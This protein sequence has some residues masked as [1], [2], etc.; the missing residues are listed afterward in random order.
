MKAPTKTF[1]I[2]ASYTYL[3]P[4]YDAYGFPEESPLINHDKAIKIL[5]QEMGEL[6]AE[7]T[8]TDAEAVKPK[9]QRLIS[10]NQHLVAIELH[11]G[12]E[13]IVEL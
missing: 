7:V 9:L 12:D 11:P 3:Q 4:S 1:R 6:V 8:A 5:L 10:R 13:G 2:Y